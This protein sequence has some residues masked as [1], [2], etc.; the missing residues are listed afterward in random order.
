MSTSTSPTTA[1]E[2]KDEIIRLREA[3]WTY[4]EIGEKLG[5]SH[6]W[7]RQ[8]VTD[9]EEPGTWLARKQEKRASDLEAKNA[10]LAEHGPVTREEFAEEFGLNDSRINRLVSDG[11]DSH[12]LLIGTKSRLSTFTEDEWVDAVQRAWAV[13]Q[14]ISPDATA[15]SGV[16][17]D[18]LRRADDPSMVLL[19]SRVGWNE[20]CERAGVPHGRS[21]RKVYTSHWTDTDIL[22][23][24][25]RWAT[26]CTDQGI[27]P[28]FAGYDAW[29]RDVDSAPSG[30]TVRN[31]MRQAGVV[32]WSDVV[33]A[34]LAE[35]ASQD[36]A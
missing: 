8:Q 5:Y 19:V 27:R 17:Y 4:T 32:A 13:E 34:G 11:L 23:W 36:A 18:G 6:E 9:V 24:V 10:W 31:R 29:Q 16:R 33:K 30:A 14:K 1:A 3:G 15:L 35:I 25:G 12:M 22:A 26:S 20:M 28:T 2:Q 21:R 7:I